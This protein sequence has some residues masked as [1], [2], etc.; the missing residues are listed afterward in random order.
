MSDWEAEGPFFKPMKSVRV[1]DWLVGGLS[2][3]R[4]ERDVTIEGGILSLVKLNLIVEAENFVIW[5]MCQH[6]AVLIGFCRAV[7]ATTYPL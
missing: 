7:P 5:Y 1:G 4:G 3:G 2:G 6:P